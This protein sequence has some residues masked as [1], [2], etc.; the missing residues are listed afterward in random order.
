MPK[1]Y[2]SLVLHAHLPYVRH[3][4]HKSFLEEQWFF[5][6]IIETYVPLLRML[7]GLEDD[8]VDYALLVS[9]S[10]T[11]VTMFEDELLQERFVDHLR[12]LIALADRE[13][14]RTASEPQFNRLARRYADEFRDVLYWFETRYQRR[15]AMAFRNISAQGR[16]ELMTCGATHGFLPILKTNPAAVRAQVQTA[17]EHHREVFGVHP[18][19]I[20]VPECAYYPG[21][22]EF[23]K[24]ADIRYFFVDS[25]GFDHAT[26]KPKFGVFAP[27]HTPNGVAV[28]ARDKETSHQVWAAE[29]GYPG[30]PD[31]REFYRDIGFDLP[32]EMVRDF[33]VAGH[34]RT[35][36]G[37]KYYRITKKGDSK[38]PYD[39]NKA[40]ERAA[41]HAGNFL[42]NRQKQ[43]EHLAPKM[44]R[45]PLIVSP[46]DAELFGHW[47]FEGPRFLDYLFRKMCY[48]QKDLKPITPLKYLQLFPENQVTVPAGS[49]WGGN[50]TYEYWI[51]N[52]N[53]SILKDLHEAGDRM[54]EMAEKD[55][56]QKKKNRRALKQMMR[57]LMLAQGS[58]WPFIM[59]TNTSPEYALKRVQS[60]LARFWLLESM[61]VSDRFD[62]EALAAME[63]ADNIFPDINPDWYCRKK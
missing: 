23:L 18:G 25:H 46:Y 1:G 29:V 4:E 13:I 27:V 32:E 15:L 48:D 62:E 20:W 9:L 35:N 40:L 45:P 34:V 2:L 24:E 61:L 54:S 49:S 60:H 47:W 42:F 37:I 44:D 52:T 53:D 3:P 38:E 28:F 41:E 14:G 17:V 55:G 10:P 43:L 19:G 30:H 56:A 59:R 12:K 6:A 50:G 8:G 22:E 58:D 21:V 39:W 57:E 5:E 11:L 36:T 33:I 63:Y 7:E 51:N 26:V 31:Y 16:L